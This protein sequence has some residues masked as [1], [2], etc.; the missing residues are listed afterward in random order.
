MA[1]RE[2]EAVPRKAVCFPCGGKSARVIA[3]TDEQK[4][5]IAGA[6]ISA[7]TVALAYGLKH[8]LED[9]GGEQVCSSD[10]AEAVDACDGDAQEGD[11]PTASGASPLVAAALRELATHKLRPM[12]EEAARRAGKWVGENAPEMDRNPL[13]RRFADAFSD[14]AK[15]SR[16]I[17][18]ES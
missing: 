5:A 16:G 4:G 14:A 15:R 17:V 2:C 3:V 7:A 12:V 18:I 10:G 8:V 1:H 6:A 13:V 9:R 11:N